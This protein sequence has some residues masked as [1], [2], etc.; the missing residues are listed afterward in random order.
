MDR[1]CSTPP[2][3]GLPIATLG[4]ILVEKHVLV[5]LPKAYLDPLNSEMRNS[6]QLYRSDDHHFH[7][8]HKF[9]VALLAR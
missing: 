1:S 7:I 9:S 6:T 8:I 5:R 3:A 2:P 4:T